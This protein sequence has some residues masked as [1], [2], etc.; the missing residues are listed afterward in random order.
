MKEL[1]R[2]MTKHGEVAIYMA[3]S[4]QDAPHFWTLMGPWFAEKRVAE[5]FGEGMFNHSDLVWTLAMIG[6]R[7]IGFGA[8]DMTNIAT[9]G[10][11]V[12]T[13]GYLEE[14][15]RHSGIYMRLLA[16]RVKL[17]K[18]DTEAKRL[19]ALCTPDSAPSLARLGFT[20]TGKRGRYTRFALEIQR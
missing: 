9:R 3:T 5:A 13:Y 10:S 17:V 2:F 1:N 6:E 15:C 19:I 14:E 16:E 7:V 18:E 12:L 11:A 20:E 4:S 8:I